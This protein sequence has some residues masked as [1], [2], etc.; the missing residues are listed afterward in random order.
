MNRI[1]RTFKDLRAQHKKAFIAFITAGY[2]SMAVTEQLV[3]ALVRAGV[4][5]IE[6]G[7]PFSDPLADGPLIQESSQAALRAG[8]N[9][10]RIFA[11]V[12]K[13]RRFTQIP[14]CLMT[15]YNPIFCFKEGRFVR[16][17]RSA[18]VD[19][20]I[21]PDLPP[22]E[23]TLFMRY[24]RRQGLDVICFVSPTTSP[25]RI[26]YIA[27]RGRGFIYYVSLTGTTGLRRRLPPDIGRHLAMI[28]RVTR[29]PVCVGFGVSTPSQARAIYRVA[30]GVIVGSAIINKI[31]QCRGRPDCARRVARFVSTLMPHHV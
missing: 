28:R 2:P 7:V 16:R 9:L 23:G 4:D 12:R 15:Y 29:K 11:L 1:E 5:I 10:N 25:K 20:V 3:R 31:R 8:T 27:R 22:E 19:G 13:V 24:A 14:L 26:Q 17:A 21:V 30:D 18:G 6:L